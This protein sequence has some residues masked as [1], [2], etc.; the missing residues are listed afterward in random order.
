MFVVCEV[1]HINLF[2]SNNNAL[3]HLCWKEN[4]VKQQK[5]SN[6]MKMIEDLQLNF[7][8]QFMQNAEYFFC[9]SNA[10]VKKN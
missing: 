8:S 1:T 2:I 9:M 3:F 5:V 6:I 4:L 10:L 7:I